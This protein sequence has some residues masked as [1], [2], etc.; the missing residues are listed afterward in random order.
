MTTLTLTPDTA[1]RSVLIEVTGAPMPGAEVYNAGGFETSTPTGQGWATSGDGTILYETPL[2]STAEHW[3]S[4]TWDQNKT[5]A[6]TTGAVAT[7]TVTGLIVGQAYRYTA[8]LSTTTSSGK[9]RLSVAGV[10]E[11]V[12]QTGN[13]WRSVSYTWTATATSHVIQL[14]L[15]RTATSVAYTY[16]RF[17]DVVVEQ[18]PDN[19]LALHIVRVDANGVGTVRLRSGQ[20]PIA[21]VLTVE[22]FE[23]ALA[24]PVRYD[25]IDG[26]GAITS[27]A[28]ELTAVT[29]STLHLPV[30]PE[31]RVQLESVLDYNAA[32]GTLTSRHD[33]VGRPDPV[34]ILGLLRLREGSLRV[35]CSDYATAMGAVSITNRGEVIMLRQPDYP[36]MDM[37]FV[38][39]RTQVAPEAS[40]STVRRWTVTLEFTEVAAPTGPLL[41]NAG[42]SYTNVT[43]LGTYAA[44]RDA[45][46]DYT[47]LVVGA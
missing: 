35:W 3:G 24:G 38:T 5:G 4:L 41:G 28:T 27:A 15:E 30:L 14:E 40:S 29:G 18:V 47:E 17:D 39:T 13:T 20:E 11:G 8:M 34:T 45:F 26:T 32:R 7:R 43:D 12:W 23:V 36:G 46:G 31:H 21:G 37:Y 25:V 16:A 1:T 22:D 19:W 2:G 42:W 33:I 9:A 6:A 44:V 10:G